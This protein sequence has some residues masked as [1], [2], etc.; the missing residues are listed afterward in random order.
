MK[1]SNM[2]LFAL[3][4]ML[5]TVSPALCECVPPPCPPCY[6]PGESPGYWKHEV[7]A[8]VEGRG[9]L[10]TDIIS[11][12][13]AIDASSSWRGGMVYDDF[14]YWLPG[15]PDTNSNDAFDIN[16]AY[17]IFTNGAYR[18]LRLGLANWYNWAAGL[19]PYDL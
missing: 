2:V 10:H 15:L 13:S 4:T 18:G 16:D 11:L 9:R 8:Y 5:V 6:P 14:G 12:T 3:L 19:A 7:V 17:A 1:I